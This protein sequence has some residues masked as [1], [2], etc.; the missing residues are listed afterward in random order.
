MFNPLIGRRAFLKLTAAGMVGP[1][2]SYSGAAGP[3]RWADLSASYHTCRDGQRQS[4]VDIDIGTAVEAPVAFNYRPMPIDLDNNGRT[5][6]Q[7]DHGRCSLTLNGIDYGLLQFHVHTPSE[8]THRGRHYPMELHLVHR[9][10]QDLA[11]VSVW[12]KPGSEQPEL[13]RLAGWLPPPGQRRRSAV[14]VNPALLLPTERRLVQYSGSLTTPPC[15]E[16]VTWLV[17][18][19]PIEA[20]LAQIETFHRRLGNN[21]RPLQRTSERISDL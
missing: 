15:S 11:V 9:S 2:W 14:Q 19:I 18:A 1:D 21:A 8:H 6:Q 12:I 13:A 4:P 7:T 20:S 16:N 5:V 17:M 10:P 3:T